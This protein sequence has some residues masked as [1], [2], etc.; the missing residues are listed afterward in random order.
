[1]TGDDFAAR[2]LPHTQRAG[3]VMSAFAEQLLR[4]VKAADDAGVPKEEIAQVAY[5]A[6]GEV[7]AAIDKTLRSVA[8]EIEGVEKPRL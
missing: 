7:L 8:A 5:Q 2:L 1:M 6:V 3:A 4:E